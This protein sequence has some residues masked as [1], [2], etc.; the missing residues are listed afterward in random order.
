V[1]GD[2]SFDYL[3]RND[4]MVKVRGHRV[5]LGEVESVLAGH[6]DVAEAAAVTTGAGIE[7]RLVAFA[8]RRPGSKPGP[9]A[10]KRHSAERLPPYMIPDEVRF[11]GKLPRTPNGKVDRAALADDIVQPVP[12]EKVP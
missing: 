8:V 10:L 4:H 6:P 1:L 5:E 7:T 12:K 9:L 3:G 2:G 11:V